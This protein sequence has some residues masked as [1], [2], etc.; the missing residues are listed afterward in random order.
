MSDPTAGGQAPGKSR[1]DFVMPAPAML[2][3]VA[4]PPGGSIYFTGP[5]EITGAVIGRQGGAPDAGAAEQAYLRQVADV[6]S[7]WRTQYILGPASAGASPFVPTDTSAV[8]RGVASA[9]IRP[10]ALPDAVTQYRR[11]TLLGRPGSGKSSYLQYL[12]L[13]CAQPGSPLAGLGLLPVLVDL[14]SYTNTGPF[15]DFLTTFLREPPNP[16]PPE[17]PLHVLSPWMADQLDAYLRGGRILL[18]V[19][20]LNEMPTIPRAA[21][22]A[23]QAQLLAFSAAYPNVRAVVACRLLDYEKELDAAGFQTVLLEPWTP[24]Q[25]EAYLARLGADM[26][27]QRLQAQDPLLL[28]LGQTPFLLYMIAELT[29]DYTHEQGAEAGAPQFLTSQS[30][31]FERFVDRLFTWAEMKED[32]GRLLPRRAV[33]RALTLLAVAMQAQG[34]RG[35]AAP[36]PWAVA[37]LP[38]DPATLF[39]GLP[40][41]PDLAADPRDSVID[42]GC[43]ATILDTP[44]TRETVRFWHLTHQD[45]FAALASGA[46]APGAPLAPA[47]DGLVSLAAALSAQPGQAIS[48]LLQR[49]DPRA[50]IV[51]AKA[52]QAA[53]GV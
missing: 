53:G 40:P 7:V 2:A 37:Q 24:A 10:V 23:R 47:T 51:A 9:R 3:G 27:L 19:D 38:G 36:H 8:L 48:D 26:L 29:A 46:G 18:L 6:Y 28:S 13:S 4:P 22:A 14:S 43:G 33:M 45:Y 21:A 35:T 42:F 34:Y 11:V 31:L 1:P 50:A 44:A 52:Y 16:D 17:Q 39:D 32:P 49:P 12:A 25:M 30:K 5:V 41:P 15:L 20:G